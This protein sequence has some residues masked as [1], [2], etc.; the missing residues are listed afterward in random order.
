MYR[1]PAIGASKIQD[2]YLDPMRVM[3]LTIE[4]VGSR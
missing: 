1:S 2:V 3:P 4:E